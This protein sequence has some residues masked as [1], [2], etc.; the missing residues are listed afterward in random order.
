MMR[1]VFVC[2]GGLLPR[3]VS[4][5]LRVRCVVYSLKMGSISLE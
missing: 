5:Q 4:E 2:G 3:N 1:V